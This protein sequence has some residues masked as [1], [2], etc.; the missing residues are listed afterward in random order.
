LDPFEKRVNVAA[1]SEVDLVATVDVEV[2]E[3]E[4]QK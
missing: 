4:L 2:D 3:T 1:E